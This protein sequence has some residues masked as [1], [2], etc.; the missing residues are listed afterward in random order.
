MAQVS[1][2]VSHAQNIVH[3]FTVNTRITLLF[4]TVGIFAGCLD[5]SAL[6]CMQHPTLSAPKPHPFSALLHTLTQ[7]HVPRLVSKATDVQK[8][9]R[10]AQRNIVQMG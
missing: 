1:G 2:Q 10:L 3:A 5:H 8:I 4:I 9:R 6:R 7:H